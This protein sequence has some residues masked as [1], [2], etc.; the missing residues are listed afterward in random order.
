MKIFN[1]IAKESKL[2]KL[3]DAA[4]ENHVGYVYSMNFSEALVLTNDAWKEK[5]SGIPH[6]SFLIASG[7]D[8]D[9]LNE[10]H[11]LDRE[12][13]LLRVLGPSGLPTDVDLLRTRIE[14]NQRRTEDE[15]F[16]KDVH[17]GLDAI[18]QSELQYG[19]L[20]CRILGTF[21]IRD[22][23]L[24]LGSDIENYMSSTK[25]RVFKPRDESLNM[26][27][28]HMNPEVM[29]KA[30]E[31]AQKSGF[32]GMPTPIEI[33]TIRYTSSDRLHRGQTEPK[34]PVQI[35]PTDFLARRTAI[36]G[37]TRTGKSN[38]LKTTVS[39]VALA[40]VK[41]NNNVGQI[42]FDINGEYANA[43]HQDDGSSIA[44][45]FADDVVCY[46]GIKTND[47][48]FRD[49]RNNFYEKPHVGLT[50]IQS[51][52]KEEQLA[53]DMK[54]LVSS[55]SL[56]ELPDDATDSEKYRHERN[57]AAF[58]SLLFVRGFT[59]STGMK[60]KLAV[61]KA[62]K[63]QILENVFPEIVSEF[64]DELGK[65]PSQTDLEQKALNYFP[66]YNNGVSL[67]E[68]ADFFKYAREADRAIRKDHADAVK[69]YKKDGTKIPT[70]LWPSLRSGKSKDDWLDDNLKAMC[71]LIVGKSESDMPIRVKSLLGPIANY[72]SANRQGEVEAEIYNLLLDGKVVILDLSVGTEEVRKSMAVRIAHYILEHSMA[73]FHRGEKNTNIVMYVEEAHN[74]IGKKE[75]LS[76]TWPRIAKEGAK[77]KIAFVYATQEPSSIH[78]NILANTENWFVTHLN[79]EDEL[80]AL[81]K[82][83][84]FADFHAS[85]KTAQ[86][87]GFARI[88]TL[89][90]P[91]VIPTQINRFTPEEL[92]SELATYKFGEQNAI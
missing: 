65:K 59:P 61:S 7:F 36:L 1:E 47:P 20:K 51:L 37:M 78:P 28:N 68:L 66:D 39:A 76:T 42:I 3:V 12:V 29:S 82:F 24:R 31:E 18:T 38:T 79:N 25:L 56:D 40:A 87:V 21:Y 83:Y 48:T 19:A 69:A 43:N 62:V 92:K 54:I 90:S 16:T 85:L 58:K 10:A 77:A 23:E 44:D 74:L 91:F 53:N 50:I 80:R 14:H 27:V 9:R 71:N 4:K 30:L 67:R 63:R 72:H 22:G 55:F 57:L 46:R 13:V 17:D 26:I 49:L 81:G 6:N 11:E 64:E 60:V 15:I 73:T 2:A 5:V 88:K 89:S 33:G 41:D 86:D 8:P 75:D 34:V 70:G 45:V 35:Q 52:L 84:D 32:S